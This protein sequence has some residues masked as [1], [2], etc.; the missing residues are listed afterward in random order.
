MSKN[1]IPT[2]SVAVSADRTPT[3]IEQ[4]E[5]SFKKNPSWRFSQADTEHPKWSVLDM[6]EDI[7]E[8]I[9]D[10]TGTSIKHTFSQSID[11]QLLDDLK[12]REGMTWSAILTQ[13][14]GRGRNGGTNSHII[15]IRDLEKEAQQ[16]AAELGIESDVLL[17]MRIDSK[18]RI[19]G[20][21][22]AG[23]LNII[24]FDREHEICPPAKR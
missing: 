19:W 8:D 1:N 11:R 22:E 21:L 20:I 24:W 16:R 9:T 14:G 13:N 7:V 2:T 5:G 3:I 23:V 10:P 12:P 15:P 17:S 4:P 18:K 6:H